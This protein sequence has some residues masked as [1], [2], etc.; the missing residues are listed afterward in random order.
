MTDYGLTDAGFRRKTFAIQLA[1]FKTRL[2]DRITQ[3]L[4]L[5]EKTYLGNLIAIMAE[6]LDEAHETLEALVGALD[7]AKATGPLLFAGGKWTGVVQQGAAYGEALLDIE[8][9]QTRTIAA[10]GLS[11]AQDGAP[12][13]IWQNIAEIVGTAGETVYGASFRSIEAGSQAQAGA[14]TLTVIVSGGTGVTSAT[15]PADATSGRDIETEDEFRTRRERS[16][17]R[18]GKATALAI[19]TEIL[20]GADGE[21]GVAGVVDCRV[22]ENDTAVDLPELPK[23]RIRVLVWDGVG[24]DAADADIAAAIYR[25]KGAGTM[26]YGLSSGVVL[27]PWGVSKTMYFD[28]MVGVEITIDVT[29]TGETSVE[30][31]QEALLS[32]PLTQGDPIVF[33]KLFGLAVYADGVESILSMTI[34]RD[35][36][37]PVSANITMAVDEKALFD[38]ARITVTLS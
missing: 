29:V 1:E 16:L 3:T 12:D 33:S 9:S 10:L 17:A 14:N 23:N 22:I 20:T 25:S 7:P 32:Y 15:N 37:P 28:R 4:R 30:T 19:Q 18:S 38:A 2:R 31:V 24:E 34:Q 27:D 5:D 11:V 13:N 35:S 8:F 6:A 36:D 21:E 26:T